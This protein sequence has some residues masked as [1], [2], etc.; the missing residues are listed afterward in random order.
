MIII[1]YQ[2][3]S[4]KKFEPDE[5]EIKEIN[6]FVMNLLSL[7]NDMLRVYLDEDTILGIKNNEHCVEIIY[8]NAQTFSSS[9]LDEINVKKILIPLTGNYSSSRKNNSVMIILGEGDYSSAPL[10]TEGGYN[11]VENLLQLIKEK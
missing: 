1:E 8:N 4:E 10:T 9:F 6:S 5:E 7:T 3:G 2:N 11:I